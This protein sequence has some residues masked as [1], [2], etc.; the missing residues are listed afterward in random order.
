MSNTSRKRREALVYHA[1]PK[2]GKIE[3]VPTKKYATQRDLSL[4][5]SPGVA[6]PCLEIEKDKEN[7]Y[8]YT[9]KGNLVAVISNGTAV[10]GLGDIGPEASKPVMEGKGLLFKIFADIDVFDI[11]V[12]TKDVDKFIETV[13]NIA[14][15]FGGI[16]LE[17]IKAPEAFEI[18]QRLKAELDIPVMHD[19]QH[20]TAIISAAALLNALE[21]AKKKIEKVKIVISGAGAAA[22]SCTKLYKAFGAKA[23]NIVMLD[24]KGVIRKDRDNLSEEKEEFATARKIDTLEEA[25]KNADVFVGLSIANIVSP[26]MLKSMAKRPIVFAMANPNPEI[27][28]DLAMKTRKDIIMATGRSD[29]PNQVN[30]VL[31]FPFIFRG[32]LDVRASK[33][34]EEMKKAAVKA[35]AELAKEAVPEQ[36]NIAYGETRLN[37]GPDYIIPKPFDPRLIAKVPPAVAKAAMDSGVA[38]QDIQDWQK[39]EEELLERMGNENKIT[40]LLINRAKTNPKRIVFAEADH[41]DVLKAAQI[42]KDEGIGTPILLGRREVIIELMGEIDF[43]DED[44]LI[45]DPKS[46]EEEEHR[47]N[48]AH[49][50]WETRHR[51]GVTKYDAEKLMR[52]RNYFAAMMVNEG[53]ADALLSGYSRAYP[54]VVKPM[55][56]LVGM[57]KGVTRVAATNVMN[58][59]RGPLFISD[60]SINIDPPAKDLAKIAQMTARTVQLF[61]MEPVIAMISYANFGSSKDPRARKV[62]DAVSYLHRFHPELSVDGELQVDFALNR[63]MLQGKFPFS[64]LAGKKVNTLIYPDLDSANSTYKLIKELNDVDSIGPIMMG[65]KKPVHILQLGA[66]VEEM[67]NMAAVA[68]VDA[69][70]KEKKLKK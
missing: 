24:S 38:R 20:G 34:N 57:A 46:D 21:L 44:V 41:L 3:V 31:G 22:V 33:I 58:T 51:S 13:K 9:T 5:Y 48:Y 29:H 67:V 45:I 6:E 66:S 37:F 65:M 7:A 30:N 27:D 32:A 2:P 8:K 36:V 43:E 59:S 4:A 47:K 62:K 17:D 42:V 53:D 15:T 19:D 64:K 52:E 60:T 70:E 25:M 12:D 55:L 1:K 14:P 56:E 50:Y 11:E 39:Y 63:E 28:Y 26:E 40:R 10:L 69:Q 23:E 54:T 68:V 61:G 18:E 16:N 49:K 35:L